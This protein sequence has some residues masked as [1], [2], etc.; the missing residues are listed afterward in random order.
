MAG[1]TH[2]DLRNISL[3]YNYSSSSE[4]EPFDQG[5]R[6]SV[7]DVTMV[8][9]S[10]EN[11]MSYQGLDSDTLEARRCTLRPYY[12]WTEIYNVRGNIGFN[13]L[14]S[15]PVTMDY[16]NII[17]NNV[18]L[19]EV[20]DSDVN[21][22]IQL[23]MYALQLSVMRA[24][25]LGEGGIVHPVYNRDTVE[26]NLRN[27]SNYL[28]LTYVLTSPGGSDELIT[29]TGPYKTTCKETELLFAL[30]PASYY[31]LALC[32]LVPLAW[33]TVTWIVSLYQVN[34][35]SRGHSQVALL[36]SGLTPVVREKM[37]GTIHENQYAV[38][39]AAGKVK[40]K[41]GERASDGQPTFGLPQ[42]VKP[43]GVRRMSF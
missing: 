2:Y 9:V 38:M 21:A 35:V 11:T 24:L 1:R 16:D 12:N 8:V 32:L 28:G 39:T 20:E 43:I 34:G 33:W 22:T 29:T 17:G 5:A 36:V 23:N 31:P 7:G 30:N 3:P 26:Q 42:E 41:F 37:R 19:N 6:D 10:H 4:A 15:E 40:V 13:I 14:S 25:V 27:F 18:Y